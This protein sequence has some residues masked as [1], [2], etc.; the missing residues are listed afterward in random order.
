M[1]ILCLIN[2]KI[3]KT[4]IQ[5]IFSQQIFLQKKK[6]HMMSV[7]MIIPNLNYEKM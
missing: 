3:I 1:W 5:S 4:S 2:F 7:F 6:L